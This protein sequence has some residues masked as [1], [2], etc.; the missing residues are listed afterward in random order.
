MAIPSG[1]VLVNKKTTKVVV[2]PRK[3]ND[4]I[5]KMHSNFGYHRTFSAV[6]EF[7]ENISEDV[8]HNFC[9]NCEQCAK[10]TSAKKNPHIEPIISTQ[11]FELEI[12]WKYNK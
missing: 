10:Y 9:K 12:I 2:P 6:F 1:N 5:D 11:P 4:I 7:Y 3:H 8:V